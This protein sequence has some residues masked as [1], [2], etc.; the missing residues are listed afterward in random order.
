MSA[1]PTEPFLAAVRESNLLGPNQLAELAGWV[2]ANNPAG[3]QAIANE[4]VARGWMTPFQTRE[5]YRGRGKDLTVGPYVLLDL[6]GEGGMGRVYRARHTRLGREEALKVIRKE[7]VAHPVVVQRFAQEVRAAAQLA[8]PN[9]VQAFDADEA[10]GPLPV[11]GVRRGDGP[12]EARPRPR[13]AAGPA[14]VRLR[15]PGGARVAARLRKEAR[16]P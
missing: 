10:D 13:A 9:V 3:P 11:D 14:G 16:P 12:D 5:V 8:H 1:E 4:L 7:K 2:S 15:P 6:V